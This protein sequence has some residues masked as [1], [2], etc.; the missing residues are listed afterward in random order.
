MGARPANARACSRLTLRLWQD[1]ICI[2][3]VLGIRVIR[4]DRVSRVSRIMRFIKLRS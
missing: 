4:V 2:L 3:E 1:K